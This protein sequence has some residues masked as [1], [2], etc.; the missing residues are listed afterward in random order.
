MLVPGN[1]LQ[2]QEDLTDW[3]MNVIPIL[4]RPRQEDRKSV[5]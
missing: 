4:G 3:H 2:Q 5:L 1:L